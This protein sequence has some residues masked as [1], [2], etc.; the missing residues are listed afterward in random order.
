VERD[1]SFT[2]RNGIKKKFIRNYFGKNS[3]DI[4]L[5]TKVL[6]DHIQAKKYF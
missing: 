1:H 3:L 5:E 6:L 4:I 2:G